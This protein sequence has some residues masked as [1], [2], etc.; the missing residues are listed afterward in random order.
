MNKNMKLRLGLPL[1]LLPSLTAA[2]A[3][4]PAQ[5]MVD[6]H[7]NDFSDAAALAEQTGDP[8]V[9]KLVT[10]FRLTSGAGAPEEI[11]AF[12]TDNPDWPEQKLLALR[13]AQASGTAS[14]APASET[15]AFLTEVTSLHAAG[16]DVSA[17]GIWQNHGPSEFNAAPPDQQQGFWPAQST[18]ARALLAAADPQ[19]AYNVVVSVDPGQGSA[20]SGEQVT[21]RD[22]LAGFIALRFLRQPAQAA[23]WFRNLAAFSPS[24]ITQGRAYYWLARSETGDAATQDFLRAAA[25]PT[26]YY[27]QLASIA[28]G[29][30]PAELAARIK[31]VSEP[32]YTPTAAL[33]FSLTELPHAGV[34]LMQMNDPHDAAIFLNR[35][36][37][38]AVDSDTRE[39]DARLALG[40]GLPQAAVAIARSA[41]SAGQMLPV[42]GWPTPYTT[43]SADLDPA[44]ADGIMR[45]ES[46]FD[47]AAISGSG[48]LGLMQLLPATARMTAHK[49]GLP[50]GDLFDT[51]ENMTLGSAY[52]ATEIQNFGNCL[53]LAIAAYNA[54]PNAV[55]RW[56][57][58]NGDPELGSQP[59][60][61]DIIDWIELI[62]YGETR[63]YVQRVSE[64]ITIYRAKLTGTADMPLTPW[65]LK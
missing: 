1:L 38:E 34:L 48:A 65:L 47:P 64:N 6:V 15:P 26:T 17:A 36:A 20:P 39:M 41:G 57:G 4:A 56:L 23:Q 11:Q 63:N 12:I 27:G 49:A 22:F 42:E 43:P 44:V 2:Q 5:I 18:L 14:G 60:G 24:V 29:E 33:Y 37:Q 9:E 7:N 35:A 21:D 13:L 10:F 19:D 55:A 40:L 58:N 25:Y 31:A 51:D 54:G 61:A 62:P 59:G 30:S 46:S 28:L 16:Q 50:Y 8:L 52:L 3:P 53:P 45:Q 32:G